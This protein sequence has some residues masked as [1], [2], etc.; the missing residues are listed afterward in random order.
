MTSTAIEITFNI[1]KDA[2]KP[3]IICSN[4]FQKKNQNYYWWT[5]IKVVLIQKGLLDNK[6]PGFCMG[7]PGLYYLLDSI[8]HSRS[9]CYARK[10]VDMTAPSVYDEKS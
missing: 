3:V 10:N 4:Q 6:N 7:W 1:H 9:V 8:E 2:V 5:Q